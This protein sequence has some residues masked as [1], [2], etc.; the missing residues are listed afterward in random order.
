ME[1]LMNLEGYEFLKAT[2]NTN[3]LQSEAKNIL[4]SYSHPWDI[5]AEALQNAVDAIEQNVTL[6]SN[7]IKNIRIVFNSNLRAIEVSDTGT[8]MSRDQVMNVL[9][10]HQ[11]LKR[12]KGLRGEKGVGL[13]FIL[14]L[15]NRFRIET[16]DGKNTISLEIHRANDWANGTESNPLKFVNVKIL[17]PQ[18]FLGSQTYTR[19]WAEQI[20]S[21]REFGEDIFEYTKPRL[22]YVLR[23]KTA[24]GNTY[25]LFNNGKRP[26]VDIVLA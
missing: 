17:P 4:D 11:G 20:P 15:T 9:A 18:N 13:S 12:G 22:K 10:P 8:G 16:C 19:I 24:I 26:E 1:D 2:I 3:R 7:A 5:L 21:A 6:H 14:F 23:T 25:P